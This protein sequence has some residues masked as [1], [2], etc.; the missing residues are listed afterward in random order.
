MARWNLLTNHGAVLA[1][2]AQHPE[3][4]AVEI[5]AELDITERSVRRIIADLVAADYL[6]KKKIGRVNRY[7][8]N[9]RKPLRRPSHSTA[10]VGSL[11][12]AIAREAE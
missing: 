8:V 1:Y 6:K 5:S 7:G 2:V 12:R 11:L 10:D 3:V 9:Y 4:T